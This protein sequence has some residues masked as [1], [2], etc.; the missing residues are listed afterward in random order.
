MKISKEYGMP[1]GRA[2]GSMAAFAKWPFKAECAACGCAMW[3]GPKAGE[4]QDAGAKV[5]CIDCRH[6]TDEDIVKQIEAMDFFPS[7][8]EFRADLL[9]DEGERVCAV[10]EAARYN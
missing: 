7:A 5:V 8:E 2:G 9:C 6:D 10:R 4:D 1:Q 3:I